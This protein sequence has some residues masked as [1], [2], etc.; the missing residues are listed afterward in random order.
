MNII[1]IENSSSAL[2]E[3]LSEERLV[4]KILR[5]L[6]KRFDMKVITIEESQ[7]INNIKVDEL[8]GSLQ[9]FELDINERSEKKNKSITYVSNTEYEEEQCD[10]TTDEGR[11]KAILLLGRKFNQVLNKMKSRQNVQNIFS[12]ISK[13]NEVQGKEKTEVEQ[14]QSRSI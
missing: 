9:T 5:S 10:L 12:D 2:R 13:N 7:Y 1:E 4:R 11:S 8:V 14:N 3:K 6:P